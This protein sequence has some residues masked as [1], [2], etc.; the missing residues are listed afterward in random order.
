MS[1]NH[2]WLNLIEVSGPF[3][4][5]TV[6]RGASPGVGSHYLRPPSTAP[7]RLRRVA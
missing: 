5:V 6:L 4:A 2:D 1:A 3:L 7:R